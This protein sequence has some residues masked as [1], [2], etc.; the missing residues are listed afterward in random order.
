MLT[1]KDLTV[2]V[3]DKEILHN[4]S[5]SL[6]KGEVVALMGPNGSGKSTLAQTIMGHPRYKITEGDILIDNESIADAPVDERARKGLFLSFQYPSEIE[7]VTVANFL[8]QAYI[9]TTG[10]QINVVKFYKLLYEKMKLLNMDKEFAKRYVNVGF[11]GGEKKRMEAL[12]L[13]LL[14]PTYAILD[15]TDSGLDVDALKIIAEGINAN[16]SADKGILVITHYTRILDYMSPDRVLVIKDGRIVKEGGPGL[17][18]ELEQQGFE[19]VAE[20]Q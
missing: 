7:G 14:S 10:E 16:R 6:K 1:I 2:N 15:E 12:Q 13:H 8:R 5:L 3:E 4:I 17:A 19:Q 20:V 18:R 9:A 11:S